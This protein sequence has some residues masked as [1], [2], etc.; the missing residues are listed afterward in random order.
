MMVVIIMII[1]NDKYYILYTYI[2]SWHD[3]FKYV[4]IGIQLNYIL[5]TNKLK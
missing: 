4:C 1:N 5:E 3:L 2:C